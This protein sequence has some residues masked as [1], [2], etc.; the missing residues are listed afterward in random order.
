MQRDQPADGIAQYGGR[1]LRQSVNRGLVSELP[2]D[3]E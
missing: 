2:S 3:G 1:I